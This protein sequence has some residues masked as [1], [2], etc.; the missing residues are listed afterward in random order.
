MNENHLNV[1]YTIDGSDNKIAE[2]II[3]NSKQNDIEIHTLNSMQNI[4]KHD[5]DA[6]ITYLDVMEDNLNILKLDANICK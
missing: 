5:I 4:T 6:G 2:S 1:I 3:E